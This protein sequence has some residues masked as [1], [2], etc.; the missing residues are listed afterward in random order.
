MTA[1]ITVVSFHDQTS[2]RTIFSRGQRKLP[3]TANIICVLTQWVHWRKSDLGADVF[4]GFVCTSGLLMLYFPDA[5]VRSVCHPPCGLELAE[6]HVFDFRSAGGPEEA[7]VIWREKL[8]K[9]AEMW[10]ELVKICVL[11][12]VL[13]L[14]PR[15]FSWKQ[16]CSGPLCCVL[17]CCWCSGQCC[18]WLPHTFGHVVLCFTVS[19]MISSLSQ[20]AGRGFVFTAREYLHLMVGRR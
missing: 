13:S 8:Q 9:W 5:A 16:F 7:C 14:S 11:V 18:V 3:R 12:F 1:R 15:C 19:S 2:I 20:D 6:Y 10:G 17:S 4:T